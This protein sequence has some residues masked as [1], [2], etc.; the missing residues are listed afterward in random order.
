[1]T[2]V[3]EASSTPNSLRTARAE[4][5]P[6]LIEL[7]VAIELFTPD[8]I[9]EL[10]ALLSTFFADE[11]SHEFWIVDDDPQLGLSGIAYCA[12][13][14]MTQSTWNLYLIGVHK[15]RRGNGRGSRLLSHVEAMVGARDGHVLLIE[16]SALAKFE[17]TRSFY[18][19]SGYCEE[20]RI[21]SYYKSGDDKVVFWKALR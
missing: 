12:P 7:L 5:M 13:E 8:E 19:K 1:M 20:A 2:N 21:R 6:S 10:Q 17:D 11:N 4:D 18:L 15:E 9:E 14:R 16:T 3:T